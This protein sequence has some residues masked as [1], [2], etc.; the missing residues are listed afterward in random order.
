MTTATKKKSFFAGNR[1]PLGGRYRLR[2]EIGWAL[3]AAMVLCCLLLSVP[4]LPEDW[5][6]LQNLAAVIQ[7]FVSG[8]VA[9][10]WLPL[11]EEA[12]AAGERVP[13]STD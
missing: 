10:Q 11:W 12:P 3:L 2:L 5:R 6:P 4:H 1:R 9:A 7:A 13:P 8:L